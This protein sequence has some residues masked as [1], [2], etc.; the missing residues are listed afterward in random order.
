MALLTHLIIEV[1]TTNRVRNVRVIDSSDCM[2]MEKSFV[3][4]VSLFS[5]VEPQLRLPSGSSPCMGPRPQQRAFS[6]KP[7]HQTLSTNEKLRKLAELMT[8]THPLY[9]ENYMQLGKDS[10]SLLYMLV[11]RA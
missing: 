2:R 4:T 7:S 3:V 5:I 11:D 8:L 1:L 9:L 6:R 10:V